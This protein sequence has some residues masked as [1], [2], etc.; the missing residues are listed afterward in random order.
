M[1]RGKSETSG[2]HFIR[3]QVRALRDALIVGEQSGAPRPFDFEAFKVRK[4]AE[5]KGR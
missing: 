4:R 1:A 2:D 3:E 5:Y